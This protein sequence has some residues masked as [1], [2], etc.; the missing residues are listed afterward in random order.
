M[1]LFP[2][3]KLMAQQLTSPEFIFAGMHSVP[4]TL[5]WQDYMW[6]YL[7]GASIGFSC[8]IAEPALIAVSWKAQ[9]VSGGA[10]RGWALRVAVAT[11]AATGVA[12]GTFRIVSGTPLQYYIIAGYV[13]VIVQ[14]IF[15][16][17]LVRALAYDAGGVTTSTVTVPVVAAL[18]L[19]LASTI[20]GRS[21]LLD[22][23]GLIALTALFPI[24]TVLGYGQIAEWWVRHKARADT[25][26]H[27]A[28]FHGDKDLAE[29][30]IA[31]GSDVNAKSFD[32]CTS[33]H[34]AAMNNRESV[35]ELLIAHG[36]SVNAKNK[37]GRTP[38]HRAA[39][40]GYPA[41]VELLIAHGAN[42]NAKNNEGRTPLHRAAF[43]GRETVAALLIAHGANVNARSKDGRTPLHRAARSGHKALVALL[44]D[45]GAD[46]NAK[47][48]D[49]RTPLLEADLYG[50]D[51]IV[52][53]LTVADPQF[54]SPTQGG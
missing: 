26:L 21:V 35:A 4:D 40:R 29:Q 48:K 11:G 10:M 3:G 19:G 17:R 9:E 36:A 12:L 8:A 45:Q 31:Q 27:R 54:W 34:R 14:T 18:G 38:L 24:I 42:V 5:R 41:M 13:V 25:P 43:R 50:H 47:S 7:F 22:G 30:L 33:L 15:A 20:P 51:N 39:F 28:A 46:I 23:F 32:G 37:E 2:L 49:G 16:P 1:A 6:V 44:I 52:E 53:M